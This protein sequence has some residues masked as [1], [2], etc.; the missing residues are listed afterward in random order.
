MK[1]FPAGEVFVQKAIDMRPADTLDVDHRLMVRRDCEFEIYRSLENAVYMPRIRQGFKDVDDFLSVVQ[2]ITQRRR[3]RGGRSLELHLRA[4]LLEENLMEGKDFSFQ[5]AVEG[6]PDFLFPSED[7]YMNPG[8]PPERLRML[9]VKS[10]VRERWQQVSGE[11]RRIR[12]KHLLTLQEGVSVKQFNAMRDEGIRLVVPEGLHS[13]YP[14]E[15][16]P[17][18]QTLE[19]FIGDVRP[20]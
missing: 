4:I 12:Y 7:A 8:F 14:Q 11:A 5:S 6:H 3:S 10:T 1:N 18:L 20:R 13:K 19:S 9:A 15:V 2:T 17:Y 16:Q